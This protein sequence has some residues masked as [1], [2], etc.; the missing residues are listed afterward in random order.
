MKKVYLSLLLCLA[1]VAAF[2]QAT[3]L[4][5]AGAA[6]QT[7]TVPAGVTSLGV[8]AIGG[9][10]GGAYVSS[11]ASGPV[12]LGGRVQCTM[13]VT[14]G[15]ILYIYV[16]GGVTTGFDCCSNLPGGFN[17]GGV[18][19]T[20]AAAGGG[21][22]D[23][24]LSA[25]VISGN[26]VTPYTATNRVVV[27]GGGGGGG[28]FQAPGGLG[29][30]LVG[31]SGGYNIYGFSGNPGD[32]GTQ[33]GPGSI[34]YPGTA[35]VG[36]A[37]SGGGYSGG[38]G[39]GGLYGGSGSDAYNGGG[40]GSSYTDPLL[41]TGVVH[42]QGY[43]GANGNG[44]VVLCPFPAPGTVTGVLSVCNGSTTTVSD[45]SGDAGGT[46]SS[47][48]PAIGT[49]DAVSGV[50][51]GI[52]NG[53]TII[54]YSVSNACGTATATAEVTVNPLPSISTTV[55]TGTAI[56]YGSTTTLTATGGVSYTWSPSTAL[57]ATTG[58]SVD[59]N[60]TSDIAYTITGTD[61]N[62]CVNTGM[63]SVTVNPLPTIS[64]TVGS[65]TAICYGST[66]T[67]TATGG[68][69][70]T[71][72]PATAL[73]ATVGTSVNANP[74][75]DIT[76]TITGT[77]GN[78][79][80]NT[81]MVSV[82]VNPLPTISTTVGS[83]TAIC[84]GSTTTL[85]AT[86]GVSYTWS[87][88][89]ALSAT[90][91]TSVDANPT[92]DI[93]YTITGIDGNGCVNTGMVSVT[94]NPIP[95]VFP[96]ASQTVC[97]NASTTGIVFD[98]TY[99]GTTT[100]NWT[101]TDASI[102]IGAS[103]SGNISSFIA[104]NTSSSPVTAVV[105][106]TPVRLTCVGTAQT[107]SITVNPTPDVSP[108]SNQTICNGTMTADII[109]TGSVSGTT[110]AWTNSD[111]SIGIGG[112]GTGDI[113][114]FT[115]VDTSV[116]PVVS[117]VTV[118]TTANGCTGSSNSFTITI[119]PTP[120]FTSALNPPAVCDNTIFSYTP[121]S[122]T[123]GTTYTWSRDT[124]TGISNAAATG[125][126]DPAETLMNTTPNPVSVAYVYTLTANGC[127][128]S[129]IVNVV[130]NPTPM[131]TTGLTPA[132]ICDSTLFVYGPASATVG[133]TF[134]WSRD[135]LAG[136]SNPAASGADT[137][138]ETLVNTT[139]E[140][141]TVTYIDTL[142]ANG[143]TNTQS[144][145]V[146]VN[147]K[148]VLT[149]PLV[150][151][152]ICDGSSIT[153][154]SASATTG[155]TF[156]WSRGVITDISNPAATGADTI[157]ETLHNTGVNP[158]NVVYVDT[159]MANGCVNTQ[160]VS[161]LVY[162]T[163]VLT[164]SL[165]PPSLCDSQVFNY[166]PLSATVGS[167]FAWDRAFVIGIGLPAA[168]GTGNPNEQMINNTND[169]LNVVYVY[170]I[171]ANGCVNTQNVTV[172]VHPVPTLFTPL[173]NSVCSESNFHYVPG[174]FVSGTTFA[175]TRTGVAGIL[176]ASG[177]GT[178]TID[179][180][181]T[182]TALVPLHTSYTYVLTANG[183]SHV[184]V[185]TLTV[186][187]TPP[188][189]PITTHSPSSL[190]SNTLFQNF[191]TS[192]LPPAG[193][194]YHWDATN[195][196]VWATG[197]GGQYCLVS[198][199]H[200]GESVITLK[201]NVAGVGCIRNNSYTVN[202]GA[203]VSD[204]PQVVYFNGQFICLQ[205]DEDSYQWGFDDAHTLD[206]SLVEGERNPNYF[207]NAP[208]LINRYYWVITKRG[209]CMQKTYYNVPTG[210][211]TVNTGGTAEVRL[212]PNPAS[213]YV[214]VDIIT[215]AEGDYKVEVMNIM[216]QKLNSVVAE[217]HKA[218]IDVASL[219]SGTYLV[220]CYRNGVKINAQRFIKN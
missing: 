205:T 6:V 52:A 131:L 12:T 140:P 167:V 66:T 24:R 156:S 23:I 125:S 19:G 203:G 126:G 61:G 112:S 175:W 129:E 154:V 11:G 120:T 163:P 160:E 28:D 25:D 128:N 208:D 81:G 185:I 111:S 10:G 3:T 21:A 186:N 166:T 90:T 150:L 8:D 210:I 149:T 22:S 62:G 58:T 76:Y 192:S 197:T 201:S 204:M 88:A 180:V 127:D 151:P 5:Y 187:P 98:G 152:A 55:G 37:G 77:D 72:S 188:V 84:Y 106:V 45:P 209:D 48:N 100:F 31:G 173:S 118:N 161:V 67:L 53:T 47:S 159:L 121:T 51:S 92:S 65:G 108:S 124:V 190:C 27:A 143:C 217:N 13:A 207:I 123:S 74:T 78:G 7:Y 146:A 168:S 9:C 99:S 73:S 102:G 105:T 34:G 199:D 86:G 29:G 107:F 219:P 70:Y 59:A 218:R 14:G 169:N 130:V 43:S 50:V 101:N 40:G 89:T 42:T 195:A 136:I 144:I 46:W 71:W 138:M 194:Q 174:G 80:V 82:T 95:D 178:G 162:P 16:G 184:Q 198:F 200:A 17:G 60:P 216:G 213:E 97:N 122:A 110:F 117:V 189:L 2:A 38:G 87:P 181:L 114:A 212:Y 49:V 57:S 176:P 4:N 141:I 196:T 202:V 155:T 68:V 30:G 132:A 91:G 133:T 20:Y 220:E 44:L 115:G 32:G 83:G 113:L 39:G 172:V 142:T 56:C 191:G 134:A 103:G 171:T 183:C 158:V 177:S 215:S 15:Q 69:S 147:P 64:T 79:C 170:T 153:Y 145:T 214:N 139:T 63:V 164:S 148:P 119:N 104:I 41:C 93:A 211:T 193:Q 36:G 85:T 206:S 182:D 109:F 35:G 137:I 94:V 1:S 18:N 135:S 96:V 116:E 54:T 75:S 157:M 179:E 26:E 33:T 165:T